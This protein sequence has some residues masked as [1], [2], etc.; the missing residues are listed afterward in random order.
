MLHVPFCKP[1]FDEKDFQ[2]PPRDII[3]ELTRPRKRLTELLYKAV[4]DPPTQ[5]QINLWTSNPNKEWQLKLLRSPTE[6]HSDNS[7]QVSGIT[8]GEA[9]KYEKKNIF[10]KFKFWISSLV[11]TQWA[12]KFKKVQANK[13]CEIK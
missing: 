2:V 1:S 4:F 7:G 6:I 13:T 9:L 3:K 12:R 8:L 11:H 5:K 10:N